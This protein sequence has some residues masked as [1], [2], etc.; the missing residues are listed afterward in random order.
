MF[1]MGAT[2]E[3]PVT[4]F[5][6]P[7]ADGASMTSFRVSTP[8]AWRR[9]LM[10]GSFSSSGPGGVEWLARLDSRPMGGWIIGNRAGFLWSALPTSDRPQPWIKAMVVDTNTQGVVLEPD[11]FSIDVAWAYPS[12]CPDVNGTVGISL[13]YGGGGVRHPVHVVGFLDGIN[14]AFAATRASTHGPITGGWGD[15]VSCATHHPNA[16]E[17]VA[18]GFTLQGGSSLRFVEPQY[19]RFD[20]GP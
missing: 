9:N 7:D 5:R 6:W 3:N 11:I 12:A 17:W 15:Y 2:T 10:G 13:F 1:F 19:A 16:T 20:V 18:A 14:W 8:G 4:I